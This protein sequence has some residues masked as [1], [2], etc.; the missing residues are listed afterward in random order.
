M[1]IRSSWRQDAIILEPYF[2]MILQRDMRYKIL[3]QLCLGITITILE[4]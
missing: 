4:Q 2:K 1:D 3:E